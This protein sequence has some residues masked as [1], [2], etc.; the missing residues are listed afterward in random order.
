MKFGPVPLDQADGAILAHSVQTTVGPLKKGQR[1]GPAALAA[2]RAD[3]LTEVIVAR[4]ETRDLH[5][6][7]AAT[8]IAAALVPDP[9]G[10]GL[11]VTQAATGRVNIHATGVG[12][13]AVD[14]AAVNALNAVNPMIT[15]ATV[16]P[17]HRADAGAMV[18]TVK[19]I[20]YAVPEADVARAEAVTGGGLTLRGPKYRT[21]ALIETIHGR[22]PGT[23]GRVALIGRL[24]RLGVTLAP[25]VVVPHE[26]AAI[27]AAIR[28]AEAEVVFVL[29]ASATSD[30]ADVAP[31][32]VRAAGGEVVQFGIP[33]D[34]GNLLFLGWLG[35]KPVIGLPGCARSPALNGADWVLERVI[36]G[37]PVGPGDLAAMGVGGLLKE[38]A[39]RPRPREG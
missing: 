6:D 23:K 29:T 36:C 18:G 8:R 31:S 14:V 12:V 5:E 30:P 28:A 21:A 25:R 13:V 4:L 38:I 37:V 7:A 11:R 35:A 15:L 17:W 16:A 19:I 33:V 34:P 24:D 2:L 27:A 10:Q 26:A 1:L 20:S 3:G 39:T 22:D 32:G 9:A